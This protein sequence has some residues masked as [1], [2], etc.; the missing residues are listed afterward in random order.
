M[1][2]I[3]KL[4]YALDYNP[5]HGDIYEY[6]YCKSRD[7]TEEEWK[8]VVF[9]EKM[10][11]RLPLNNN[12]GYYKDFELEG[13]VTVEMILDKVYYFYNEKLKEEDRE[14][15][16]KGNKRWMKDVV[17]SYSGDMN[18]IKNV[19]VFTDDA[20]PTFEGLEKVKRKK[21]TYCAILGPL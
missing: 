4:K 7:L 19:D 3:E 14:K 2:I 20:Y 9:E 6:E 16:F 8:K 17:D 13:P 10:V 21:N 12:L 1:E 15:A 18:C 11:L 5:H